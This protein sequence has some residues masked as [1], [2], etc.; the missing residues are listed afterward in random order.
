MSVSR[1]NSPQNLSRRSSTASLSELFSDVKIG[2]KPVAVNVRYAPDESPARASTAADLQ[3]HSDI[4]ASQMLAQAST[5]M[6]NKE[7]LEGAAA[8][9]QLHD[10]KEERFALLLIDA[11]KNL[12]GHIIPREY[13]N[14]IFD[15]SL[16][17]E[18]YRK[19]NAFVDTPNEQLA[20]KAL[21]AFSKCGDF[22][23]E[24]RILQDYKTTINNEELSSYSEIKGDLFEL[25]RIFIPDL[26]QEEMS[27]L[28]SEEKFLSLYKAL[29]PLSNSD[30]IAPVMC[31][32]NSHCTSGDFMRS[33]LDL[34]NRKR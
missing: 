30:T 12:T 11:I 10:N 33:L 4:T 19:L 6:N 26:M 3:S 25:L 5:S 29:K 23:K 7:E 8:S 15:T 27:V 22:N 13:L 21:D 24:M 14:S 17:H 9:I 32:L 31:V 16:H 34:K 1:P 20:I 2:G 18:I 28:F